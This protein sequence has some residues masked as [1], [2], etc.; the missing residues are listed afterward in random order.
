MWRLE[1][2][3]PFWLEI[4]STNKMCLMLKSRKRIALGSLE[5]IRGNGGIGGAVVAENN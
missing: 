4:V 5:A 3:W 2:E 1:D